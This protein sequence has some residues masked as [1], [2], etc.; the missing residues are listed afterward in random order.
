MREGGKDL[1]RTELG[2]RGGPPGSL[3]AAAPRA[4]SRSAKLPPAGPGEELR[5]SVLDSMEVVL[6]SADPS[7]LSD[8]GE[9][10]APASKCEKE[11]FSSAP[12]SWS[13]KNP[14]T[15][16]DMGLSSGLKPSAGS[17]T[18]VVPMGCGLDGVGLRRTPFPPPPPASAP[19][20]SP[21][22]AEH[23]CAPQSNPNPKTLFSSHLLTPTPTHEHSPLLPSNQLPLNSPSP[24]SSSDP[25]QALYLTELH[26]PVTFNA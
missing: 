2:G 26:N 24:Q 15:I 8:V 13:A 10:M 12:P 23:R 20:C 14:D 19:A 1:K 5:P 4:A 6:P 17:P 9:L 16:A 3:M 25:F 18:G 21:S 7:T 11:R 22:I